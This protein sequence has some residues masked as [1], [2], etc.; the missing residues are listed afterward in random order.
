LE[1]ETNNTPCDIVDSGCGRNESGP[2]ENDREVEIADPAVRPSLLGEPRNDRTNG[3]D[4]E[5]PEQSV[6]YLAIGELALR[7]D[8]T[9]DYRGS[10]EHLRTGA[11]ETIFLRDTAHV[12]YI[13]KHPGLNAKLDC[14]GNCTSN[15]LTCKHLSRRNLHVV[16]KFE[17]GGE[18]KC[19]VHR[20][21]S[22]SLEQHHGERATRN[23]VA[24]DQFSDNIETDLL[25]GDSLDH[26][27]GD[28]I[29]E[30]NHETQ[31][32][33]PDWELGWP[34][35]DSDDAEYEHDDENTHVPP[36]RNPWVL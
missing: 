6:V 16:S 36:F 8:D 28:D 33:T 1:D 2:A 13:G 18:L 9:P 5:E 34:N 4:K 25:V 23:C 10:P 35:F 11:N 19:L 26:T 30:R 12:R 3:A 21:V 29:N 32:E 20:D 15:H 24:D 31:H 7:A 22:P 17:V 14:P 27:D